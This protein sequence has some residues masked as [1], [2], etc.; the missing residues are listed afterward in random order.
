MVSKRRAVK[1]NG[2]LITALMIS[3]PPIEPIPNTAKCE[4]RAARES[5]NESDRERP[6]A[7]FEHS[8]CVIVFFTK[9]HVNVLVRLVAV[10]MNMC[11]DLHTAFAE[12][13]PCRADPKDDQ[14]DR[15]RRFHPWQEGVRDRHSQQDYCQP[16]PKQRRRMTK[17]PESTDHRRTT[18]ALVIA[19][20]R[21]DCYEVVGVERVLKSE[22]ES[23]G[24]CCGYSRI[25]TCSRF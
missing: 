7:K 8:M 10:V 23:P 9:M 4:G 2:T 3:I 18:Q 13:P 21:G 25:H 11:V 5:M 22:N 6:A 15:N 19:Y 16:D 12:R 24:Q 20:D 1:T 17:T 14:H